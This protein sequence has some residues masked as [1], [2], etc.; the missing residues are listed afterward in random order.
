VASVWY[1]TLEFLKVTMQLNLEQ[2]SPAIASIKC[3]G[4][5]QMIPFDEHAADP[6]WEISNRPVPV[7][8]LEGKLRKFWHIP[9]GRPK[10]RFDTDLSEIERIQIPKA[11]TVG[12]LRT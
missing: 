5:E 4:I 2:N 12:R 11:W 9:E 8:S 3:S 7:E 1:T 6:A 10:V